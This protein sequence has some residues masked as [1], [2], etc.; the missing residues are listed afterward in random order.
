MR[1]IRQWMFIPAQITRLKCT[2][3][4]MWVDPVQLSHANINE[5]LNGSFKISDTNVHIFLHYVDDAKRLRRTNGS[6]SH[7]SHR[8]A[9]NLSSSSC[10]KNWYWICQT[11][12]VLADLSVSKKKN[13]IQFISCMFSTLC[14]L[15]NKFQTVSRMLNNP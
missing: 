8:F 10:D 3:L 15:S 13:C 14:I 9:S 1:A 7:A 12:S 6:S 4:F 2:A 11:F 5:F